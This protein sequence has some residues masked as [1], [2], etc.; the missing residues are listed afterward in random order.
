[1]QLQ[2]FTP[3]RIRCLQRGARQQKENGDTSDQYF[4]TPPSHDGFSLPKKMVFASA[5]KRNF[6]CSAKVCDLPFPR[7]AKHCVTEKACGV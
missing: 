4:H 6:A 2:E 3:W 1:M 7:L 5:D